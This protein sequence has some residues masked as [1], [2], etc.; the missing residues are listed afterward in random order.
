MLNLRPKFFILTLIFFYSTRPLFAQHHHT[1]TET[2]E[3]PMSMHSMHGMYGGYEMTREASGTSWEP[4]SS[5]LEGKH[6]SLG[7]WMSMIQGYLNAN[8]VKENGRRGDDKTFNT[9]M[10]M[11]MAQTPFARGNFGF[12]SMLSLEP[13]MGK[14]GYPLLLQSGETGNGRTP[15]IDRQHPHDLFMEL[16]ETYNYQ[17]SKDSSIFAYFGLPGEPA[18]GP[19]A[20]MHRFSGADIPIAPI[21][22]HWLDSTHI[23][24]GVATLGYVYKD[25][26]IEGS[27]FKGRE[28]NQNRWDIESPK[29]DSGSLRLSFN[30]T[31]NWALQASFGYLDSPEQLE[32]DVDTRRTTVSAMYNK[33]FPNANWQTTFAWGRNDN[34]PGKVLNGFLLESTICLKNIHTFFGRMERVA[35]DELFE[36]GDPLYDQEFTVNK[37]VLGYIHDFPISKHLKWGIGSSLD[38]NIV[39]DRL[40]PSYSDNPVGYTVFIRVKLT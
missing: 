37:I 36:V 5:P 23:T 3:T 2:P 21:T 29:F 26:K 7:N 4:E 11:F 30:P 13:L 24:Y 20:F 32:P 14:D 27:I 40:K 19:P 38:V 16:A 34:M 25:L 35:K 31:K 17:I 10:F 12:R 15:L 8:Y 6:F 9:S 33:V 18:L 1:I 22:H 28:P 39:P